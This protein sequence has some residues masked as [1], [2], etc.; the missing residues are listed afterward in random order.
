[1]HKILIVPIFLWFTFVQ[2]Q[3]KPYFYDIPSAPDTYSAAGVSARLVDGLG[4]RYFWATE[5]LTDSDLNFKPSDEART[6]LQTIEH[7]YGLTTVLLNTVRKQPTGKS[8]QPVGFEKLREGTLENLRQA[9][10]LLRQSDANPEEMLMIFE[11]A[12]GNAEYPFWNLIN[13][14]ISDALWHVGQVVSFRR[15]SG[16]P[17]PSGVNVLQG[18]KYD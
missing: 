10:L 18:K 17:L 5:G 9:S 13:G 2:A 4:F 6:S 15:S 12:N 16:N 14:P 1:M 7:I 3:E 11:R 8:D